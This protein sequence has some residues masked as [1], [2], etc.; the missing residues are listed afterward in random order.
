MSRALKQKTRKGYSK[1]TA[2]QG[3]TG[4]AVG[5]GPDKY[6]GASQKTRNAPPEPKPG[7]STGPVVPAT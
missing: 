5:S 6:D 1:S 7:R 3:G 4:S 2:Q